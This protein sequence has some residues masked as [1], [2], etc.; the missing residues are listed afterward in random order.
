MD[1]PGVAS[2]GA[3]S[4]ERRP[5]ACSITC[6]PLVARITWI[7]RPAPD[8]HALPETHL[9]APSLTGLTSTSRCRVCPLRA[10]NSR[11]S[12]WVSRH[13]SSPRV[14]KLHARGNTSD[15]RIVCNANMTPAD[16]RMF[17]KLDASGQLLMKAAMQQLQ[18]SAWAFHR[19]LKIART[20]A[21]LAGSDEIAPAFGRGNLILIW[22]CMRPALPSPARPRRWR[23]L[24]PRWYNNDPI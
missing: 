11:A 13:P 5:R 21:D 4:A 3:P 8:G 20:I 14:W 19:I 18:L 17:C 6:A 24:C 15:S 12:D 16:V 1:S 2:P 7:T 22:N 10:K 9:R 23:A